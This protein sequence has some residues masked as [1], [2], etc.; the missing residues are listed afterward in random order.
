[1]SEEEEEQISY[2][3]LFGYIID[4][5]K[6]YNQNLDSQAN[7]DEQRKAKDEIEIV[8]KWMVKRENMNQ[9]QQLSETSSVEDEDEE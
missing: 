4:V 1:M 5:C 2:T 8:C 9:S 7:L 6:N 3:E